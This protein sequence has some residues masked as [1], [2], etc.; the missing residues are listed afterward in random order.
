LD[1]L[2]EVQCAECGDRLDAERMGLAADLA[3]GLALCDDCRAAKRI[4]SR[5]T[6]KPETRTCRRCGE[7]F[8]ATRP[9]MAYCSEHRGVHENT[10]A[11]GYGAAHRRERAKWQPIV[12]AGE[13]ECAERIC[14]KPSRLID[15]EVD[16]DWELAHTE[17]R[18]GYLGPAHHICNRKERSLRG[19]DSEPENGSQ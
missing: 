2:V 14:V 12:E 10:T 3:A 19:T 16:A 9:N 17:D 1:R 5:A 13:A 7:E 11:R 4:R 15:P 6:F 8:T 18:T